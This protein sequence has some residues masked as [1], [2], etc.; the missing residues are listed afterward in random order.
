MPTIELGLI[1]LVAV[2]FGGAITRLTPVPMPI[3]LVGVG[4]VASFVPGL[5]RVDIDPEAFLL[6][7]IPPI[8]YADAWLLPR[9]D[10]VHVIKPVLLL[11]LG[12][13]V[14]TVVTVGYFIHWLIPSM[15]LAVAFTLGAI[16]SPT[17]AVATVAVSST[18]PLP[19]RVTHIVN[20]ESLLNDATGIVAFKLAVAAAATG[21]FSESAVATQFLILSGGGIAVGVTV[22]WLGRALRQ[23]LLL[24]GAGDPMQ[25]TVLSLLVPYAAYLLAETLHV[26]G[27]LAVV[28]GGLWASGQE[29]KGMSA[30][31]RRHATEV[32]KLLSYVL[33]GVVFV[34]LGL[35]LRQMLAGV[36]DRNPLDVAFYALALWFV[37]MA[38][39][40]AWVWA[41]AYLRFRLNWGWAGFK[42]GPDARRMLLV[43][44]AAVRGSI[45][46]ATALSVPLLTDAGT[47]FP[48]RDLVVFLAAATIILS[49]LING[50]P[51]PWII[52]RLR[53][54]SE[55][56]GNP[57]EN[58]ARAEI[59][60]TAIA[61]ISVALD[62]IR[63]PEDR[64][65]AE[66]LRHRYEGKVELREGDPI[67]SARRVEHIAFARKLRLAV[68]EAERERLRELR[69]TGAINDETVRI[70][71]AELD[72]WEIMS[73]M[74]AD[75]G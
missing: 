11:A 49:L 24:L 35:Q 19:N 43:S 6:L 64:T 75:R 7:F 13:V 72:E 37:L 38:L 50:V 27:V 55:A 5:D 69:G 36:A 34:L 65:Y 41:S 2:A 54:P 28:A 18:V 71:E 63:D 30:E 4:A 53:A 44:W 39:R 59:A 16:V 40:F 62:S 32:W 8:L 67:E 66:Q 3:L 26:S 74:A 70:I 56:E 29:I 22:E 23:R 15:P 20:A 60:K 1:L 73:S 58:H 10:F 42:T 68:I 33:N 52:K 45:T 14:L 17:D 57:E 21:L 25:Q 9:R 46:L 12:L 51:L 47:P 48:E 31:V 61:L